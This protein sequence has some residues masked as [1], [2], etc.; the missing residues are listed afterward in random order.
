MDSSLAGVALSQARLAQFRETVW[1]VYHR[2]YRPMEWRSDPSPY[3]VFI[4][5]IML[6]QTQVSRVAQKFPPFVE[7]FPGFRELAEAPFP[8]VLTVWSGLGYNRRARYA[9]ESARKILEDQGGHLPRDTKV[10]QTLPGIG[11]NTAGSIAAFA[12][13]EPVVFIET[14]IRRVF[15]EHFFPH[16]EKVHDREI[17]PLVEAALEKDRSREWYWAL[18]DY[19]VLLAR[20]G[21]NANRRSAHYAVQ[22]PFEGSDRQIRGA[23]LRLLLEKGEVVA[24]EIPEYLGVAPERADSVLDRLAREGLLEQNGQGRVCL[25]S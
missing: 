19:G 24:Q 2:H 9:Q 21:K 16:R 13:N 22:S 10:L 20:T 8:E 1:A 5:E 15:L 18:M 3:R 25:I 23:L 17:L 7:R 12:F 6:Q 4:S 14:N 11:P